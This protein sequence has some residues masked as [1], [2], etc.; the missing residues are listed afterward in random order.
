MVKH[1]WDLR[2]W[3]QAIVSY[4]LQGGVG[5]LLGC[6]LLRVSGPCRHHVLPPSSVVLI[7]CAAAL[8]LE[9]KDLDKNFR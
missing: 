1:P 3:H 9:F 2:H 5:T 7:E 6:T 8:C 4:G